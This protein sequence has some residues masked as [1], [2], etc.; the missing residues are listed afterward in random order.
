MNENR[1]DISP[2]RNKILNNFQISILASDM[3]S[4]LEKWQDILEI[5]E[6]CKK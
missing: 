1:I 4:S 6:I 3:K 2:M 5:D